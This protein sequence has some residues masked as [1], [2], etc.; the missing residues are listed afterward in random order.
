VALWAGEELHRRRGHDELELTRQVCRQAKIR[1]LV[2]DDT[3][4]PYQWYLVARDGSY[5]L[6]AVDYEEQGDE[7]IMRLRYAYEAIHGE[8][9]IAVLPR[10]PGEWPRDPET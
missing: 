4:N 10:A 3:I 7:D 6:A 1:A 9:D 5:G 8:P 2:S